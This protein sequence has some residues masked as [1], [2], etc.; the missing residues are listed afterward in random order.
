MT[1]ENLSRFI[2]YRSNWNAPILTAAQLPRKKKRHYIILHELWQLS[3]RSVWRQA[4]DPKRLNF[5]APAGS[6]SDDSCRPV[7]NRKCSFMVAA[8]PW[9]NCFR[10]RLSN[11]GGEVSCRST[12][13]ASGRRVFD[14]KCVVSSSLDEERQILRALRAVD[15]ACC[16]LRRPRL[17]RM[18]RPC[19]PDCHARSDAAGTVTRC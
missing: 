15:I 19:R 13:G 11:A 17:R 2:F 9:A 3:N 6:R 16:C 10:N 7:R 5:L 4:N 12:L 1:C 18:L 8:L 14:A